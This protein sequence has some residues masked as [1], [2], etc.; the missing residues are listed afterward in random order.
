MQKT[1]LDP[2]AILAPFSF[3]NCKMAIKRLETG[4]IPILSRAISAKN[5]KAGGKPWNQRYN[6]R[7]P[8]EDSPIERDEKIR[9]GSKKSDQQK[10]SMKR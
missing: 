10:L 8:L 4:F 9:P 3:K 6:K 7:V 1:K 5:Q 2:C